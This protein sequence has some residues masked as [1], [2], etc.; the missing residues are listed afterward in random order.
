MDIALEIAALIT[1]IGLS[2]YFSG[3]EVALV[4]VRLSKIEQLVKN[5]VK[6]ASS[7]HKLKSNP[8]R[9]M[10]SV[11]LGNNLA[12]IAAVSYTHLTLPTILLV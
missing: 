5:K 2:G 8:S 1:L 12:S 11:N 10:S 6:G 7:L 9:M 3:L 4:S